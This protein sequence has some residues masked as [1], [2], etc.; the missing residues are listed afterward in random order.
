MGG[1]CAPPTYIPVAFLSVLTATVASYFV[2][3]DRGE[4]TEQLRR[5]GGSRQ[6]WL[7]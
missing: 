4:E 7:N 3:S 2:K 5:W 1:V 6:R